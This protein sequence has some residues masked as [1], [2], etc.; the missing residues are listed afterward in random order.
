MERRE[1]YATHALSHVYLMQGQHEK[2]I[3]FILSTEDDWS[4]SYNFLKTYHMYG[5]R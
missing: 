1:T 4:V 5:S 2:G 3:E